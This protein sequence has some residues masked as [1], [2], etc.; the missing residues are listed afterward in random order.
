MAAV[1]AV[2]GAA[3]AVDNDGDVA[4]VVVDNGDTIAVAVAAG[5]H[6]VIVVLAVD[7]CGSTGDS[8]GDSRMVA[9]QR[10]GGR[11]SG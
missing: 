6:A 1:V 5:V 11:G 4:I 10:T 7:V 9:L 3:A 8:T 2:G